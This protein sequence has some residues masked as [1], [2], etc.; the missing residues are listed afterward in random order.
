MAR[1]NIFEIIAQNDNQAQHVRRMI[2]LF[3]ETDVVYDVRKHCWIPLIDYVRKFAFSSWKGR[4]LCVDLQDFLSSVN[5]YAVKK[6]AVNSSADFLTLIEIVYNMWMSAYQHLRTT[7]PISELKDYQYLKTMLDE[8]L[9]RWNYKAFYVEETD[10]I[11]VVEDKPEVTAVA[12]ITS[13]TLA[14]SIIRYNHHMLKGDLEGKKQILIQMARDLE[15]KLPQLKTLDSKLEDSISFILNN[16]DIRHN[17]NDSNNN[18]N[19][20]AIVAGMKAGEL[21]NWY[22]ELYQMILL[23]KLLLDNTTRISEVEKLKKSFKGQ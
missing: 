7:Y 17:N 22:D 14:M 3:E 4:S 10:Q 9:A 5:Y 21:E 11:L 13:Q 19:Y 2:R 12:E 8:Y 23:A 15:P 18:K 20:K 16:F 1:H 6:S